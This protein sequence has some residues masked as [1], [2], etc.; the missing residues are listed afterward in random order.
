MKNLPPPSRDSDSSDLR[1]SVRRYKYRKKWHGHDITD[2]EVEQIVALYDQ[3]EADSGEASDSLKGERL[4]QILCEMIHSAYDKTQ[5]KRILYSLRER[6]F[7][8]VELCPSCGIGAPYELDHHLP[9]SIFKPLAIHA[10]NLI[11]MCHPCNN[12]K[13]EVFGEEGITG[14]LHPYYNVLPNVEFLRVV[15]SIQDEALVVYFSIDTTAALP[16]GWAEKLLNQFDTLNLDDRYQQEV[17]TYVTSHAASLH[18]NY[19][20]SGQEGVRN[21]LLLQSQFETTAF[22]RNHWRP[23]LLRALAD[24]DE[25]TDGGFAV[26]YPIPESMIEDMES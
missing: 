16:N 22:H 1:K 23:V 9:R 12:K 3:Y 18:V 13:K 15:V 6:L 10:R 14:F 25:F 7:K 20:Q 17:N 2:N 26:I 5:K 19:K 4:Q 11:P 24:L 8:G 21:I